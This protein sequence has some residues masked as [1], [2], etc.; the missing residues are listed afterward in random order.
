L[1]NQQGE[2]HNGGT[3]KRHPN[4]RDPH[5][6]HPCLQSTVRFVPAGNLR[7]HLLVHVGLKPYKCDEFDASFADKS[8]LK[9]HIDKVHHPHEMQ[10]WV[11]PICDKESKSRAHGD[12][13]ILTHEETRNKLVKSAI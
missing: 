3:L 8:N 13:Y 7:K 4:L 10:K 11:C 1:Y 6:K 12:G 9:N 5:L 2:V